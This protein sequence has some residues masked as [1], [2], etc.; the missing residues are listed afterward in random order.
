MI[1]YKNITDLLGEGKHHIKVMKA[2]RYDK[3]SGQFVK[4]EQQT[5]PWS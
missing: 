1:I 2:D 5:V 4:G 3:N